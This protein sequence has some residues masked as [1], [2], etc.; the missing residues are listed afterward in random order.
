MVHA[1]RKPPPIFLSLKGDTVRKELVKIMRASD[2]TLKVRGFTLL[3]IIMVITLLG[4]ICAIFIPQYIIIR[5]L[6]EKVDLYES[7]STTIVSSDTVKKK[8]VVEIEAG[9]P[10]KIKLNN[11]R[12]ITIF[13]KE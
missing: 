3:E 12:T 2:K 4:I 10:V 11:G 6:K 8:A 13:V 9:T 5:N 1:I 7:G